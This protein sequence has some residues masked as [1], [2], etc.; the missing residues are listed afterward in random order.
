M[1]TDQLV[2]IGHWILMMDNLDMDHHLDI[3]IT[4]ASTWYLEND[5]VLLVADRY[6]HQP[7]ILEKSR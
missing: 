1:G 3:H 6:D 5:L 4:T 2:E 7:F